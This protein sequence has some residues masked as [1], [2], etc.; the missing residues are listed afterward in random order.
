MP[1]TTTTLKL[2]YPLDSDRLEDFPTIAK[3]SA[4]LIDQAATMKTTVLPVFDD[5]WRHDPDGGLV[6]TINGVNHLNISLR[7]IKNS[8]HMDANGI[9][10]IYRVNGLVKVPSTREIGRAH[11]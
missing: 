7:R 9:V 2:P 5:A 6:R 3:Q 8:F 4:Q 10:D 11:V 1:A